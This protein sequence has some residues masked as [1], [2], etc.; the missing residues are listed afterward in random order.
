M[1]TASSTRLVQPVQE[2]IPSKS[3]LY[4]AYFKPVKHL[5]EVDVYMVHHLFNLQDP[6]GALH[7]ASKKILLPGVRT[8]GK[9]RYQDIKE[10]RD[11][12][13]R[14]LEINGAEAE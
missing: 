6:S 12:L 7:H 1:E 8:G 10:A 4:P 5:D 2:E 3:Q 9:S 13:N 14:W 11:S